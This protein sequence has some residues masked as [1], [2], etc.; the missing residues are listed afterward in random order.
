[1]DSMLEVIGQMELMNLLGA[2]GHRHGAIGAS[3]A[4]DIGTQCCSMSA[5]VYRRKNYLPHPSGQDPV[6]LSTVIAGSE[7]RLLCCRGSESQRAANS[8]CCCVTVKDEDRSPNTGR[9]CPAAI[10]GHSE[11]GDQG[12]QRHWRT[13]AH[14]QRQCQRHQDIAIPDGNRPV[15]HQR[16][17][18]FAKSTHAGAWSST[19]QVRSRYRP[20]RTTK[21]ETAGRVH[22]INID[23]TNQSTIGNLTHYQTDQL[24]PA[25]PCITD[26]TDQLRSATPCITDTT[27]Q[28]KMHQETIGLSTARHHLYLED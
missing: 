23:L 17:A 26:H 3:G 8:S 16:L 11:I 13:V 15:V 7:R 10:S 27:S 2:H 4:A 24:A 21:N 12:C 19:S 14:R 22:T 9:D 28:V 1:M 5:P 6:G 25:T 20:T 18:F